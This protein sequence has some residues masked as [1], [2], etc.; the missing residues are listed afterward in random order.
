MEQFGWNL[1]K[2]L[3]K[4]WVLAGKKNKSHIFCLSRATGIN[5]LLKQ[6][7]LNKEKKISTQNKYFIYA[8]VQ[9]GCPHLL[10]LWKNSRNKLLACSS[11]KLKILFL[12][13]K[14]LLLM[15]WSSDFCLGRC[16]FF[17]GEGSGWGLIWNWENFLPIFPPVWVWSALHA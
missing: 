7:I 11:L 17:A 1:T 15:N 10:C 16:F 8:T 6:I 12:R 14:L 5:S 9:G 4:V 13:W 3:E 2:D